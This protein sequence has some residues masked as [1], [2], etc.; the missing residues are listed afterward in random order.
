MV[1][2]DAG[3][4]SSRFIQ[5]C[6]ALGFKRLLVGMRGNRQLADG[7]Q[8]TELKQRGEQVTLHDLPGQP[9]WGC[10]KLFWIG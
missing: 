6:Q 8:F 3:F 4:G 2:A 5:G 9:L 7:R 1:L 10:V